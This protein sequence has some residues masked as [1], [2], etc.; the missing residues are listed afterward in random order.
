MICNLNYC[1]PFTKGPKIEYKPICWV[2]LMCFIE[3]AGADPGIFVRGG[4]QHPKILTSKK[5]K[6]R[7]RENG[8]LWWFFPFY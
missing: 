8:G 4:V 6:R 1:L 7:R 3:V 5:K 2:S